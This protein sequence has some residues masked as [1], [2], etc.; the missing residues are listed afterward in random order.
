MKFGEKRSPEVITAT[1]IAP[2]GMNCGI[3]SGF[4]RDGR[5]KNVCPGCNGDDAR[6]PVVCATCRIKNCPELHGAEPVLCFVCPTY[7]CTRMK[8][9]DKRYRTKYGMSM[10]E[11]LANIRELGLDEFAARERVRWTCPGCGGVICV[12]RQECVYC[13]RPRD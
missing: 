3:C 4:L 11:N 8:Q 13:G 7:P 2:C 1:M 12:H 10:L 6:K 9:L 5:E